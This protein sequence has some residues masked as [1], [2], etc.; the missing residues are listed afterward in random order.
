SRRDLDRLA[1][2]DERIRLKTVR[3]NPRN[4]P[5]SILVIAVEIAV[6]AGARLDDELVVHLE[7]LLAPTGLQG[8][9]RRGWGWGSRRRRSRGPG[10]S[11]WRRRHLG[12]CRS[13]RDGLASLTAEQTIIEIE[14]D[15]SIRDD[16]VLRLVS[17]NGIAQPCV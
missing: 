9:P 3:K 13:R 2:D 17:R 10:G 12:G 14:I 4:R 16:V 6:L 5:L 7:A 1:R 11:R 8:D 15:A